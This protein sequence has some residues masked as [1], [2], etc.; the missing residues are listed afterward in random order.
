MELI[1]WQLGFHKLTALQKLTLEMCANCEHNLGRYP[2]LD[3]KNV[4]LI[5]LK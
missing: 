4:E 2:M 3:E 1:G 5:S